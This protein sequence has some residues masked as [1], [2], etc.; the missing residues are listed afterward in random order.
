VILLT[1]GT[2]L[3]FD[4]LVTAVDTWAGHNLDQ[5]IVA[6]IGPSRIVPKNFAS[7]D[8]YDPGKFVSLQRECT[9]MVAHAGMGSIISAMQMGKPIVVMPRDHKRGEHRN[10]HQFAT[11]E[12]F[13]NRPGIYSARGETEVVSLLD[14]RQSLRP[15]PPIEDQAPQDFIDSLSE[16]LHRDQHDSLVRR[17]CRTIWA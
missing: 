13:A 3:P 14:R 9:V 12:K 2:Q 6:Q 15:S 10:G 1:V 11:V 4:R 8:F 17:L 7:M 5:R 16:Y